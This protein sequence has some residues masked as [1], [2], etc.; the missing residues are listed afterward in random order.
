MTLNLDSRIILAVLDDFYMS[1]TYQS[2]PWFRNRHYS[3]SPTMDLIPIWIV[4]EYFYMSLL[5]CLG[6]L[7][8]SVPFQDCKCKCI[9][10]DWNCSRHSRLIVDH[11]HTHTHT[12]I[13]KYI[14]ILIDRLI[15]WLIDWNSNERPQGLGMKE[16]C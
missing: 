14:Y 4:I 5:P 10:F 3:T 2:H 1:T 12:R 11:S 9:K 7:N 13:N 15:D 8:P 6:C 16:T